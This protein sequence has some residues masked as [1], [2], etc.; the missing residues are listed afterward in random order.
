[1]EFSEVLK[2]EYAR[3]KSRNS[4]YSLRAYARTLG[5][6]A[7]ALSELING[8]RALTL[9][10]AR[11]LFDKLELSEEEKAYLISSILYQDEHQKID[12]PEHLLSREIFDIIAEPIHFLLLN[13]SECDGFAWD[14]GWIARKID[15]SSIE[16][17]AA[18]ERLIR[19]GLIVKRGSQYYVD[20]EFI[21]SPE[22]IPSTAIKQYHREILE[23]AIKAIDEQG[24]EQREF[25]GIGFAVD[26]SHLPLIKEEI[27]SFMSAIT[28][29]YQTGKKSRTY[30]LELALFETTTEDTHE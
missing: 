3:K 7:G 18:I 22:G 30:H 8:K 20:D 19:V 2:R 10:T 23:R 27:L 12:R 1:M 21:I 28:R 29:K 24:L 15:Y 6:S 17:E 25:R 14:S 13:L 11:K 16:I 4:A 5:I 26:P 9:K